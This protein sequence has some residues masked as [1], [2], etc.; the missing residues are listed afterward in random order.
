MTNVDYKIH[1][2]LSGSGNFILNFSVP[3]DVVV[4][5]GGG[6]CGEDNAGIGGSGGGSGMIVRTDYIYKTTI[7]NSGAG[8]N[9]PVTVGKWGMMDNIS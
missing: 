7:W 4:G 5:G 9:H 1:T 6:G 8:G 3:L 2:C